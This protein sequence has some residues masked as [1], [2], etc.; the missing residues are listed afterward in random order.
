MKRRSLIPLYAK[1]AV[2]AV[3]AA[4]ARVGGVSVSE[5]VAVTL[6]VVLVLALPLTLLFLPLALIVVPRMRADHGNAAARVARRRGVCAACGYDLRATPDRCPECG[7]VP[8]KEVV[9]SAG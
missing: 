4:G 1:A 9:K 5:V 2:V 3:L 8:R 6:L 7:A